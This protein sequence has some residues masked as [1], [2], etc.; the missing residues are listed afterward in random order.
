MTVLEGK[1]TI[2]CVMVDLDIDGFASLDPH[3]LTHH[4]PTQLGLVI[5]IALPV[6]G[7]GL[8]FLVDFLLH[9]WHY[10][11]AART[12][13]LYADQPMSLEKC[14]IQGAGQ[15]LSFVG[16]QAEGRQCWSNHG[17]QTA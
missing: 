17:L 15:P 14:S 11:R 9:A 1:A 3:E 16:E 5:A 10:H 8:P 6:G 2:A 7:L 12:D 13:A 4:A